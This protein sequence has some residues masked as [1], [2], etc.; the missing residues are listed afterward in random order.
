MARTGESLRQPRF[1]R[2]LAEEH[3]LA[4]VVHEVAEGRSSTVVLR[5]IAG[6]GKTTLIEWLAAAARD[7]GFVVL[8]TTGV[9]FESGVAY[10]GLSAVLRPVLGR[11]GDLPP[12]LVGGSVTPVGKSDAAARL[13]AWWAPSSDPAAWREAA[14]T[15]LA[16][17]TSGQTIR[18]ALTATDGLL[19]VIGGPS[20]GGASGGV[21]WRGTLSGAE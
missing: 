3:A 18:G 20:E 13:A 5:G 2:R 12:I 6:Q 7:Q 17:A 14:V 10:S 1:V 16:S 4:E 15:G 9:E 21:S 19:A 11:V 8:R